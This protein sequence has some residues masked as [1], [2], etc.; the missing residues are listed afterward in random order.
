[1]T[2]ER[3]PLLDRFVRVW[4]QV[5]NK[6]VP[7]IYKL[8]KTDMPITQLE[9]MIEI[10]PELCQAMFKTPVEDINDGQLQ[11]HILDNS[12]WLED[13]QKL[14]E[15]GY[16]N[17]AKTITETRIQYENDKINKEIEASR[18]RQEAQAKTRKRKKSKYVVGWKE[19]TK[20]HLESNPS[21]Y[22][23]CNQTEVSRPG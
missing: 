4:M 22:Y 17:D 11:Q 9:R 12:F 10:D 18:K 16:F 8:Q 3:H 15:H 5:S 2:V 23:Q 14:L 21:R 7:N 20:S 19:C 6:P 1:M 13:E